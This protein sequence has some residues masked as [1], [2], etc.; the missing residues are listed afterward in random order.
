MSDYDI[1][2]AF[3]RI[4]DEL[5]S[6]MIRNMS[7]HRAEETSS[8]IEWTMWQTEQLKVLEK[9]KRGNQ[10]KYKKQFQDIN[11]QIE[12][13]IR[14]SRKEG[15]MRQEIQILEA[16]RGGYE[17]KKRFNGMLSGEFFRLNDRKLETLIKA[18]THDMERAETAVLRMANDQYRKA[19]FN[20]QVYANTGAGT[21]EKAVDMATKNMLA[22]GLNC[23][24]YKNGAR[25][26]LS[27]YA[28]MA[29]RTAS[30]RAYLQGEGEKRQEWG[31]STVIINKRGNPC[32]KCFPFV[33]KVMIDDVWSGGTKN[34]GSYPLIST[35]IAKGLYHPRCK[36]SHTT[37]F[38]NIST[39]EDTWSQEE[40]EQIEKKNKKE[41]QKQYAQRQSEKFSRLYKY[42]LSEENRNLYQA[43]EKKWKY[44]ADESD[45]FK[46]KRNRILNELTDHIATPILKLKSK[47]IDEILQV[48]EN[49]NI[50]D[51]I[52]DYIDDIKF[53]NE[54]CFGTAVTSKKGIRVNLKKDEI[55]RRGKWV[56]TF[57]EMGHAIDRA[58][59]G[60]SS[61]NPKFRK[62]LINDFNGLVN[63]Y[64]K[65]Y[66][67]DIA[68]A[69]AEIGESLSDDIYHSVSDLTGALSNNKCIGKYAH[70]NPNYWNAPNKLEKEAFAHFFEATARNDMEKIEVIKA[71]FP[72][73]YEQFLKLLE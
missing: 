61:A 44:N 13:L 16:I 54:K 18:T 11:A 26:T 34:D 59:G 10:K 4:E 66:N 48:I 62:L 65:V 36:D 35:A 32:P 22:A 15:G 8:G 49:S 51:F 7:N 52:Y 69:F 43:K 64:C 46:R 47:Y 21:Y 60:L 20:A 17:A 42:S 71:I 30:K 6:S 23:I 19:I 57:H 53:I 58:A 72:N 12:Q 63:K 39:Q 31:I 45:T 37:Y 56:S 50:N 29:I 9:Y 1:T 27:D 3:K 38:K 70:Y 5:I 67:V 14:T 40:L 33:G 73:A 28:D 68:T 25:H 55:N 2:E 24:Q 41:A